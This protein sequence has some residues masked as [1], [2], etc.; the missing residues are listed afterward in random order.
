MIGHSNFKINGWLTTKWGDLVFIF[1]P[2]WVL[3]MVFFLN[4]SL[5]SMELPHWAWLVFILGFDV[6]H[7]WSTLF[8]TYLDKDEVK[9]HKTLFIIAPIIAFVLSIILLSFSLNMFWRIMAY[10]AVFH[11][12]KQQYGFAMLY[13]I[14]IGEK[15]NQFISDKLVIYIATIYPII[16]WHF[17]SDSTF[18]WF[19]KNDFF[20]IY[21]LFQNQLIIVQVFDVLNYVYWMIIG[22]WL[23]LEIKAKFE[24]K[25][26]SLAKTLWVLTT[27]VNWWFG[28]VYYNSDV[29][30]SISNVVAHGLPYIVL[31]YFYGIK[32]MEL[33]N[34]VQLKLSRKLKSLF[35][36]IV[37]VFLIAL[38]EEYFWDMF[39]YREHATLFETIFPYHWN[40]LSNQWTTVVAIAILALPQQVHYIIDGYI[41]KFNSK[42]KYLKPMFKSSHES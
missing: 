38:L 31:I 37:T 40:Q 23:I 34:Q 21:N 29:V 15:K 22:L 19:V 41:W 6:S 9:S 2:V 18:N 8:R 28:I 42:N 24:G 33:K 32:K 7:V 16:F 3:W 36:L 10:I 39:I 1:L 5:Q 35:I 11:F 17:N 25:T 12:I 14:K 27:A 20:E 4:P 26:V 30:F 13:K